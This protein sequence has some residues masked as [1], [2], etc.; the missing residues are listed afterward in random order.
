M[1]VISTG[2]ISKALMPGVN[3]WYGMAYNQY[4]TQFSEIFDME[5]SSKYF[6][7]DVNMNGFGLAKVKPEAQNID[8][9]DAS[10]SL[11]QRYVHVTYALGYILSR[12]NIE[13]NQYM[14]LAEQ[15][16]KALANSMRQTKENVG[17]N[18]LNRGFNSSYVGADNIELFSQVHLRTKG[19][20]FRNELATPAD[21]SEASLE[22]ACIDV[23]KF[24]DDAGLTLSAMPRKLI[25]P[26]E[27]Q[28]EAERIL[29]SSLQADTANNALNAL[30]NRGILPDGVCVN[31]Y[32]TDADAFFIKTDVSNG[33]KHMQRR[34][35]A[36]ENDT[37]FDS[38]NVKFKCTERYAFG[39]TDPRGMF[40]SAGA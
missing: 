19:G 22:Q 32:L 36:M 2:N 40:A 12:E 37:D 25:I 21:L 16:T 18:V 14:G 7:E 29:K 24:K 20:T 38:E 5:R 15:M 8:Y 26:A 10:Q 35:A 1:A 17:A 39:W 4:P 11:V 6:E 27:L 31:Q 9:T 28:F 33:L 23:Q 30:K 13:D 3:A 34:D